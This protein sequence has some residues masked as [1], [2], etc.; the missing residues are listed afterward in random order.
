MIMQTANLY[1]MIENDGAYGK[2]Q[3]KQ[4][5]R[6]IQCFL[7]FGTGSTSQQ[8]QMITESTTHT[9]LTQDTAINAGMWLTM[10]GTEYLINAVNP[11]G[12]FTI[13]YL[14]QQGGVADAN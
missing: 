13:L 12:R 4:L 2:V 5:L 3:S 6:S 7:S 1:G 11:T 14:Q 10:A 8:N 9:A